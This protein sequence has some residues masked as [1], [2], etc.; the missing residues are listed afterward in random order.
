MFDAYRAAVFA[1]R[2]R[3]IGGETDP[4]SNC[5]SMSRPMGLV[6]ARRRAPWKAAGLLLVALLCARG[7]SAQA[8]PPVIAEELRRAAIPATAAAF[9]VQE[10]GASAP[11]LAFNVDRSMNPASAMKLVTTYAALELLGP[12][13]TWKTVAASN[14]PI[15]DTLQGDLF[16]KGSGDPKLVLESFWLLL[17]Q[18][19]QRGIRDISGDLVLDRSAFERVP[20]DPARFDNEALRTYNVGPDALLV[21][22]KSVRFR[23]LPDEKRRAVR[24][25]ADPL[26]D[27]G[28]IA[29]PLLGNGPCGDWRAALGADFS[30]P[31]RP[32]FNG[33]YPA[34]CG[35]KS[36]TVALLTHEDY[37]GTLFRQ[38]W[39][40]MGGIWR[41]TVRDGLLPNDARVLAEQESPV[42]MDVVRDI[43]KF[44]NNV[45]ARQLYLS[46]AGDVPGM[47][48]STARAEQ[49]VRAFL[50]GKNLHMPELVIENGSGL[51]RIERISARNLGHLLISAHASPLMPEFM[52]SLP[53]TGRDGTMRRRLGHRGV[54]GQAHIKTGS[55]VDVR[56][57]AGYVLAASGRRYAVVG[58]INHAN[59]GL[60]QAVHDALLEWVYTQG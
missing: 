9:F 30:E 36:W 32:A 39:R 47:P 60:S 26:P 54:A 37:I 31:R 1:A 51:S 5:R 4:G 48:A 7:V 23:F 55:L 41:G 2:E 14:A 43:N 45:M 42:L 35:E 22:F 59:A 28:E 27:G 3:R 44:S 15:A 18:L 52:S 8:L 40:E 34:R 13:F 19:R 24:V 20:H 38:L 56:S 25:V 16:L 33:V 29:A 58:L 46:M 57:V 21:N 10:V 49:A 17:R 53:L 50:A 11:T 12:S 6:T